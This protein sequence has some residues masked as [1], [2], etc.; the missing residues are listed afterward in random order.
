LQ[1]KGD[2]YMK[3]S[4]ISV[5]KPSIGAISLNTANPVQ[6]SSVSFGSEKAKAPHHTPSGTGVKAL[7]MAITAALGLGL[8]GCEGPDVTPEVTGI[9][10]GTSEV[11][12]SL[13]PEYGGPTRPIIIE[14][15]TDAGRAVKAVLKE[16]KI[17]AKTV[18]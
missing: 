18:L 10:G 6:K 9:D 7:F 5:Y 17:A 11:K 15:P 4:A 3:T 13:T 14:I 12:T 2:I 16:G 8:A 1:N